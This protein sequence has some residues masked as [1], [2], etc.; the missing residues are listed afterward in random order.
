MQACAEKGCVEIRGAFTKNN[1][2][3]AGAVWFI[4]N[5]RAF[6]IFS[7]TNGEAKK[8]SAMYCLMNEFIREY[9]GKNM[10][11]DFEGSNLPGVA[12]FYKG[13]GTKECVY[14]Q[15]QKNNFPKMIRWAYE[16]GTKLRSR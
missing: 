14:L 15:V 2:L 12:G 3:C 1:K 5:N 10:V 9:A 4:K 11:L 6:Y 7:A 16:K 8:S 13:F